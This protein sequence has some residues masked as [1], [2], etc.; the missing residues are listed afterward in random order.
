[1]RQQTMAK[2]WHVAIHSTYVYVTSLDFN[3]MMSFE[4]IQ[5]ALCKSIQILKELLSELIIRL[6]ESRCKNRKECDSLL[7]CIGKFQTPI[8]SF[9]MVY[10]HDDVI[11]MSCF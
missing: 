1:M 6:L 11:Y 2:S 8:L 10:I 7:G 5:D 3:P 4:L 9:M